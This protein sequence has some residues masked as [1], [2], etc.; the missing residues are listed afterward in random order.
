MFAHQLYIDIVPI[1]VRLKHWSE[2]IATLWD[3]KNDATK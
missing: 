1:G 3:N 2:Y